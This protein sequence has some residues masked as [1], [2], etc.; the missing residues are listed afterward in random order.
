M[1]PRYVDYALAN[2]RVQRGATQKQATE[3]QPQH[4]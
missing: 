4:A 2:L 1:E 3:P